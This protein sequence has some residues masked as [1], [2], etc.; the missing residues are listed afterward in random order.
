MLELLRDIIG[1]AGT[2]EDVYGGY[3]ITVNESE[4]FPWYKVCNLLLDA[5]YEVW[6][7]KSG[8]K[9]FIISK[10]AVD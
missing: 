1:E 8:V 4:K 6:M 5:S 9:L 2:V 3:E 7:A 10:P